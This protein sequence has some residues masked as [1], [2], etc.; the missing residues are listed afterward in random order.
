MYEGLS[1]EQVGKKI[2]ENLK[3]TFESIDTLLKDISA[4]PFGFKLTYNKLKGLSALTDAVSIYE[5]LN[6]IISKLSSEDLQNKLDGDLKETAVWLLVEIKDLLAK[7]PT[8]DALKTLKEKQA[9]KAS[10]SSSSVAIATQDSAAIQL[11]QGLMSQQAQFMAEQKA[12][13][14]AQAAKTEQTLSEIKAEVSAVAEE[15]D[16]YKGAL[17]SVG[18]YLAIEYP[19]A[20]PGIKAVLDKRYKLAIEFNPIT[21]AATASSSSDENGSSKKSQT[22]SSAPNGYSHNSTYSFHGKSSKKGGIEELPQKPK[23]RQFTADDV[24]TLQKALKTFDTFL[25]AQVKGVKILEAF[26]KDTNVTAYKPDASLV[27]GHT[28]DFE[29]RANLIKAMFNEALKETA[30]DEYS[31]LI[32][33]YILLLLLGKY[34]ASIKTIKKI[35][36]DFFVTKGI[37]SSMLITELF[38]Q[39][40]DDQDKVNAS[41]DILKAV[42]KKRKEL[43][44]RTANILTSAEAQVFA[45]VYQ[46]AKEVGLFDSTYAEMVLTDLAKDFT[47]VEKLNRLEKTINLADSLDTTEYDKIINAVHENVVSSLEIELQELQKQVDECKTN[48]SERKQQLSEA[49][50]ILKQQKL[51]LTNRNASYFTTFSYISIS[52]E[53]NSVR[54]M[55]KIKNS[56]LILINQLQT[57]YTKKYELPA[58]YNKYLE[59][60]YVDNKVLLDSLATQNTHTSSNSASTATPA[61]TFTK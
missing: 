51:D 6:E 17:V 46:K 38:D 13:Q 12:A 18:S 61:S 31:V 42:D 40:G 20:L 5:Q 32:A 56:Y 44:T 55:P 37:P 27:D 4:P 53:S 9:E 15:R 14:E 24:T 58:F 2:L 52:L 43:A 21:D 57:Y 16:L 25:S 8:L 23:K 26:N 10:E 47:H 29:P 11:L 33:P 41:N 19:E 36:D 3:P 48:E 54:D 7:I 45:G 59:R 39:V 30:C 1:Y 22:N 28:K 50:K 60:W 49:L 34:H 35:V